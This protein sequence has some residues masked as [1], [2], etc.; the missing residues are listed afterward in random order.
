MHACWNY[1]AVTKPLLSTVQSSCL[2]WSAWSCGCA[3]LLL[4]LQHSVVSG[5]L[6]GYNA[7]QP[8]IAAGKPGL[9]P[10]AR[11]V[12]DGLQCVS[13]VVDVPFARAMCWPARQSEPRQSCGEVG[14]CICIYTYVST[15]TGAPGCAVCHAEPMT[16]SPGPWSCLCAVF[17]NAQLTGSANN[18]LVPTPVQLVC[19]AHQSQ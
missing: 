15:C 8:H 14:G 16:G 6:L 19:C 2:L 1:L 10:L 7:A 13:M 3:W 11:L 9:C 18:S 17:D 4:T 5:C 12:D